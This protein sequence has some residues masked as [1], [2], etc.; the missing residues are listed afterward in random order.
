VIRVEIVYA[1]PERSVSKQL[2]LPQGATLADA[3]AALTLD[4]LAALGLNRANAPVGIFGKLT[5]SDHALKDADR[6]EVYRPLTEEPKLARR[7][8][9]GAK[10]SKRGRS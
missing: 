5:Q 9:A 10:A 1:E 7:K 6:I 8:R 2:T 4:E 3:L